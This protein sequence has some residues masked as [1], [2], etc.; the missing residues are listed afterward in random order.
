[1]VLPVLHGPS[2]SRR[3][4]ANQTLARHPATRSAHKEA[5]ST[6]RTRMPAEAAAGTFARGLR[7]TKDLN[8][9][10]LPSRRA[11]WEC[12]D[13]SAL[14]PKRML[15]TKTRNAGGLLSARRRF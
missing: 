11:S 10:D 14:W 1:M 5:L 8:Q 15:C 6:R 12:A 7:L 9:P 2:L 13:F 3:R 4:A